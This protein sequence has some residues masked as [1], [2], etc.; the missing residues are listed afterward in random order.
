MLSCRL[1]KLALVEGHVY[2]LI[3]PYGFVV[4]HGQ[5]EFHESYQII[6]MEIYGSYIAARVRQHGFLRQME[7]VE[8]PSAT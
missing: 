6:C 1:P 4:Y 8:L 7:F 5:S 2:Q 3:M